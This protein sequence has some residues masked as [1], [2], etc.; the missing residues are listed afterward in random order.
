MVLDM[1]SNEGLQ[2]LRNNTSGYVV[3]LERLAKLRMDEV[4]SGKPY[5]HPKDRVP[6]HKA[7]IIREWVSHNIYDYTTSFSFKARF[8]FHG[9]SPKG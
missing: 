6:S 5:V 9:T 8:E 4:R 2:S 3:V 1:V 7:Y